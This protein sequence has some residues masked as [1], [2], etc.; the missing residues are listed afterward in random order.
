[1]TCKIHI[2]P[3]KPLVLFQRPCPQL[4]QMKL[5]RIGDNVTVLTPI[6]RPI[7]A[8][9]NPCIPGDKLKRASRMELLII[10]HPGSST[11]LVVPLRKVLA[12]ANRIRIDNARKDGMTIAGQ[13]LHGA[14]RLVNHIR[15][16]ETP[17]TGASGETCT[18]SGGRYGVT[19][20]EERVC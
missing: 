2:Q 16:V 7:I 11:V 13:I 14:M 15:L 6:N 3:F 4:P 1:M 18:R 17:P 19:A 20:S 5:M 8:H 9:L 12:R 10:R